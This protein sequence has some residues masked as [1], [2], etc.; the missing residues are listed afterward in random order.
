MNILQILALS[1]SA[2]ASELPQCT[3]EDIRGAT[4]LFTLVSQTSYDIAQG[5]LDISGEAVVNISLGSDGELENYS[6]V[7]VSTPQFA[8][9]IKKYIKIF[10]FK[11]DKL[12]LR[13]YNV[14]IVRKL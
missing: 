9:Q 2:Q 3:L 12:K 10:K 8:R 11:G 5:S 7:C 13:T 6:T 1:L 4:N 14:A